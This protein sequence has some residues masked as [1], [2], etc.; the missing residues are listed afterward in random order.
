MTAH[1]WRLTLWLGTIGAVALLAWMARAALFPFAIGGV[2]AYT[3]SPVVDRL[4]SLVPARSH[5]TDTIRRG[6]AVLLIYVLFGG[7]LVG[8]GIIVIPIATHQLAQFIDTVP[9]LV[10]RTNEQLQS[11]A[12]QYHRTVPIEAQQRLD[13]YIDDAGT[14]LRNMLVAAGRRTLLLVTNTVA[15]L[16]GFAVVPFWM[17]YAMRDRHRVSHNFLRAVPEACRDDVHNVMIVAD[18]LLGRYIRGQLVLGL[19]VGLS[20]GIGLTVMGVQLSVAL[21]VFAGVTELIPIVGP[22]I[23]SVPGILLIAAT[24][25]GQIVPVALLY[26]VVQQLENNFLV[27]KVQGQAVDIHPAMVLLLLAIGG[28]VYGLPGLIA[29][30]PLAAILREL[31]WYADRRLSGESPPAALGG[32]HVARRAERR[33]HQV[34]VEA[35]DRTTTADTGLPGATGTATALPGEDR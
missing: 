7:A 11:W 33:V 20:V 22:W 8:V 27:P 35:A 3:L 29:I 17:F 26:L 21:G 13:G 30:V 16:F 4:A 19:V 31:F 15:V 1:R 34:A 14:A 25:P 5:R 28:A 18:R 23:G 32:T 12:D 2:L 6:V 24:N 10:S 9:S